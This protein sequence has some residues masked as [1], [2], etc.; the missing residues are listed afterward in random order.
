MSPNGE[1][2]ASEEYSTSSHKPEI[3]CESDLSVKIES[4]RIK[5]FKRKI[6]KILALGFYCNH[7]VEGWRQRNYLVARF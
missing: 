7:I 6:Q 2:A 4:L 1:L 5:T 3:R